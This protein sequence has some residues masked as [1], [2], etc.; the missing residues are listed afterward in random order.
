MQETTI[1]L[2]SYAFGRTCGGLLRRLS[3]EVSTE[4]N[5]VLMAGDEFKKHGK[6]NGGFKGWA[7][8]V[9]GMNPTTGRNRYDHLCVLDEVSLA[10]C[11]LDPDDTDADIPPAAQQWSGGKLI[12][13]KGNGEVIEAALAAG[14]PVWVLQPSP[15]E[16][17]YTVTLARKVVS[18]EVDDVELP[19]KS[20]KWRRYALTCA[21]PTAPVAAATSS[22]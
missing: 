5:A 9:T 8:F 18:I 1:V 6:N 4:A 22:L 11:M 21:A 12:C 16:D 3:R 2:T 15:T 19:G 13:S 17:N 10:E 20:R 14:R 7:S